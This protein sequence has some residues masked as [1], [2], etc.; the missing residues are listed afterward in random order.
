M[1]AFSKDFS[2][3]ANDFVA[4]GKAMIE[5][6]GNMD[7]YWSLLSTAYTGALRDTVERAPMQL[8]TKEDFENYRR[9]AIEAFEDSFTALFT[10]S[11][12]SEVHGRLFGSQLNISKVMQNIIEKDF[13]ILNLPTRS[14]VDEMLKDI[15]ELKRTVRDIKRRVEVE[16]D[17]ARIAT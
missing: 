5:L 13:K 11:E 1:Y 14:E 15:A 8:V 9:A 7:S 4:L 10:S 16:N 3:F 6:K 12:F 17:Q 2:S